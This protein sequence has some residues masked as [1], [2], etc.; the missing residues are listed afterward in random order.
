MKFSHRIQ[1]V[2]T[3]LT[4]EITALANELKAKGEDV[5]GFGA[6]EPDFDTPDNVK[7]A[8]IR[9]IQEND[10]RYTPVGG[11]NELKDAVIQKLKQDNGLNYQR[12]QIVVS[13]GA[14]HS[15]FNLAQVL[16]EKG[17]EV[18]VPAPYWLSYP[19]MILLA[20][21]TPIIVQ[22]S[23]QTGFK[24]TPEQIDGAVTPH[25]RAIIINS[26]SNPTGSAYSRKELEGIAEC[27]LKHKLLIIS[28][29]IYEKIVFDG[30]EQISIASLGKEVQEN[31]VVING[32]S[33][34]YAMTGWRIG[35]LAAE[36]E[37]VTQVLKLQSQ[38]TSNPT[39][40]AQAASIE[41]LTGPQDNVVR[42]VEEF[43]NRR[44]ILMDLLTEI[45]G[46]SCY[47]PAGSFYTFPDFSAFYGK[48][49]HGETVKGSVEFA[50]FLLQEAKVALV[51]GIAFGADNNVRLSFAT[52]QEVIRQ[53][54]GRIAKAVAS[55]Q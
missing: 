43:T 44:N 3:S 22:T 55:L 24:V 53:G 20:G 16:W 11:T 45:E 7:Q 50:R 52:S 36:P 21:G 54:M 15:F 47:R 1:T 2:K 37:I 13:C 18:L 12:N 46:V 4:L 29:E 5:I 9:A 38:S 41:A 23:E 51:P 33:K 6:G 48:S 42:M 28:D 14:K 49:Y 8:A 10:T 26:P 32:M 30:F 34:C 27:A 17:D 39:S 19:E 25:T 40:I 31:C 35:Y